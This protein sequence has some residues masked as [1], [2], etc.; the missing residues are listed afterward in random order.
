MGK[1]RVNITIEEAIVQKAK[2]IGLNISK[3]SEN[4]LIEII[5]KIEELNNPK[6]SNAQ[7]LQL[8]NYSNRREKNNILV[9]GQGF[10]PWQAY[11]IAA[12][13]LLL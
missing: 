11:A 7:C 6:N 2:E 10:E 4:A 5:N 3:I 8:T 12:S 9:R 1:I 13:A